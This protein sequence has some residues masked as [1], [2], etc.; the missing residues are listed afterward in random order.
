[1]RLSLFFNF[2]EQSQEGPNDVRRRYSSDPRHDIGRN[3]QGIGGGGGGRREGFRGDMDRH[4]RRGYVIEDGPVHDAEFGESQ[5]AR[6]RE[7][8]WNRNGSLDRHRHRHHQEGYPMQSQSSCHE[9]CACVC[10]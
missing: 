6:N 7:V 9:V 5:S 8:S 4:R 1:L 10:C 2:A 3:E